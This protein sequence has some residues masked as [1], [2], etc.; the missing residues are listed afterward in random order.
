MDKHSLQFFRSLVI[1]GTLSKA[2]KPSTCLSLPAS[3]F[4]KCQLGPTSLERVSKQWGRRIIIL[5]IWSSACG[6]CGKRTQVALTTFRLY[7]KD[8]RVA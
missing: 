5:N 8:F 6:T 3:N 1:I 7:R 2:L 4:P